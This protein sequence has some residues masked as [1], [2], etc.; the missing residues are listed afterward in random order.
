MF[1]CSYSINLTFLF[2]EDIANTD[3]MKQ[4]GERWREMS[5]EQK[6]PWESLAKQD[7][8]RYEEEMA[9]YRNGNL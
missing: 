8:Q 6:A 2:D 7:K 4:T 3:I 5:A 1:N 9:E